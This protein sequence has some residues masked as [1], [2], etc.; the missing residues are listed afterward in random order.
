MPIIKAASTPHGAAVGYHIARRVEGDLSSAELVVSVHSWPTEEDY[1]QA[2]ATAGPTFQFFVPL[3]VSVLAGPDVMASVEAALCGLP[4]DGHNPCKG[5][6]RVPLPSAPDHA[7]ARQWAMIKQARAILSAEPITVSGRTF[8]ADEGSVR[9][10][11]GA[12]QG[13]S[14]TGG[15]SIEWTLADNSRATLSLADLQALGA[16]LMGRLNDLHAT[17]R[18]LR[19]Q[20]DAAQTVEEIRAVVWPSQP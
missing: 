9:N 5:G 18:G 2:G 11:M 19:E 15:Q 4:V 14:I 3:P 17:A 20:L 6:A 13:M 8:D 10:V 12:L 1:L 16:S 7:R